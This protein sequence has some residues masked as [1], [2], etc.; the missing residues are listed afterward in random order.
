[1]GNYNTAQETAW[2]RDLGVRLDPDMVMIGWFINDAEPTPRPSRNWLASHSYA[3]VGMASIA[4]VLL[5]RTGVR[6]MYKDYYQGL[7]AANQPG[8]LKSQAA[9]AELGDLCRTRG[10]SLRILLIPE[11]HSLAGHYEFGGVHDLIREVGKGIDTPVLDLL[12]AFPG[13]ADPSSLWVSPGDAHPNGLANELMARK[14]DATLRLEH[15]I[16]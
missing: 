15:W 13:V 4:D 8:W 9:F 10:M 7:Y 14:I 16:R 2:F 5:R 3:Y 6:P 11:L 1:M 12:D